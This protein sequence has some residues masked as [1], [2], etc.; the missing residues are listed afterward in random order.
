MELQVVKK[1]A[2]DDDDRALETIML[3]LRLRRG[4]HA[5]RRGDRPEPIRGRVVRGHGAEPFVAPQLAGDVFEF[6][7]IHG[8]PT[9]LQPVRAGGDPEG[10][11]QWLHGC[12]SILYEY[13]V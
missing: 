11:G 6:E 9:L 4:S 1:V 5:A 7:R 12:R 8:V 3:G 2:F 13:T 10:G